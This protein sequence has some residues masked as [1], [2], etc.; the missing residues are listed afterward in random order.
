VANLFHDPR[1]SVDRMKGFADQAPP[2]VRD[3]VKKVA[4]YLEMF[5]LFKRLV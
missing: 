1:L 4:P 5:L 2:E 3:D